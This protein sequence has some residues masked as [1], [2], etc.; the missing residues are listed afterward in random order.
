MICVLRLSSADGRRCKLDKNVFESNLVW[1]K[2][3][4]FVR[5]SKLEVIIHSESEIVCATG[6]CQ[7]KSSL[8]KI[9]T[10]FD[11]KVSFDAKNLSDN[12]NFTFLCSRIRLIETKVFSFALSRSQMKPLHWIVNHHPDPPKIFKCYIWGS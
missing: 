12:Q 1:Y 4:S 8:W 9:V 2:N 3:L 6:N 5:V 7:L 10:K 11:R